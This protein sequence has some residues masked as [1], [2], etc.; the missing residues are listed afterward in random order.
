MPIEDRII[1][2]SAN[3]IDLAS[4]GEISWE[5]ASL[6]INAFELG[7]AE[8]SEEISRPDLGKRAYRQVA[9]VNAY[10]ELQG[11]K[12]FYPGCSKDSE[13][14]RNVANEVKA[15]SNFSSR[16]TRRMVELKE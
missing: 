14:W 8:L 9:D 5:T 4:K 2:N 16:K 10:L 11:H 1:A 12:I 3:W 13:S 15:I 6:L 7:V